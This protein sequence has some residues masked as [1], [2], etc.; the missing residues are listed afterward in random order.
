ME[1]TQH[2]GPHHCQLKWLRIPRSVTKAECRRGPGGLGAN[3]A[4]EIVDLAPE[5]LRLVVTEALK[6]KDEVEVRISTF[7]MHKVVRRLAEVAWSEPLENGQHRVEIHFYKQLPYRE[8][9]Q[10]IRP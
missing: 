3:L 5:G 6:V 4:V 1:P 7:G 9:Q 10:M 8:L 2:A